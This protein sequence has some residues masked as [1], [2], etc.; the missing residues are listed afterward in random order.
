MLGCER[1]VCKLFSE[2]VHRLNYISVSDSLRTLFVFYDLNNT[3][4]VFILVFSKLI[5]LFEI[6]L[7]KDDTDLFS[8]SNGLY[9]NFFF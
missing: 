5:F 6:R 1:F 2:K 9:Y 4:T 8:N 7:G 3:S